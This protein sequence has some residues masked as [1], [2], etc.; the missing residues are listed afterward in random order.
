MPRR[1][2]RTRP[3]WSEYVAAHQRIAARSE[4]RQQ[5]PGVLRLPMTD[6][7]LAAER[8]DQGILNAYRQA[9]MGA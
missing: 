1:S 9:R 8:E 3:T 7:E 2:S 5:F 4:H 6:A